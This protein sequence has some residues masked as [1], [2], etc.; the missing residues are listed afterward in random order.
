MKT[1]YSI[2]LSAIFAVAMFAPP[3]A[4]Q[5][6]TTWDKLFTGGNRFSVLGGFGNQAV[7]DKETGLVWERSPSTTP[8]DP[9]AAHASCNTE[10]VGG[11]LG[12]RLPT[13]QELASLVDQTQSSPALTSG[14]PFTNVQAG[15]FACYWSATIGD[16]VWSVSFFSNGQVTQG[17]CSG[18]LGI[19][20]HWC[21]RG[22]QGV[23][24]QN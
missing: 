17:S 4:A 21:V 23:D 2:I 20:Y 22:G 3:A 16:P 11:R 1:P 10:N 24:V 5:V 14:H 7:L 8:T 19:A 15:Q 6:G 9:S 12:W 18:G 13:I